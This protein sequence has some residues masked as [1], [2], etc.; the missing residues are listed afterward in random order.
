MKF[1]YIIANPNEEYITLP[2]LKMFA[3]ANGI[4]AP[5]EYDSS[6]A[7]KAAYIK[8]IS[9]FAD[10]NETNQETVL[11]WIDAVVKEGIK[12]IQIMNVPLKPEMEL[13]FSAESTARNY[14]KSFISGTNPH[15]TGNEYSNAFELI[16]YDLD[17]NEHGKSISFLFCRMLRF[18]DIKKGRSEIVEYPVFAEY[19]Y[20]RGWLI[21]RYKSRSGLYDI[22]P[23]GTPIDECLRHS[24]SLGAEIQK[25]YKKISNILSFDTFDTMVASL[26]M[27]NKFYAILDHYTHTPAEIVEIIDEN[28][29]EIENIT[30]SLM[31][32]CRLPGAFQEKVS[33]DIKNLVEKYLSITWEDKKIFIQD[34]EAYPI[35]LSTT[36]EE[37]SRVDQ[38]SATSLDPLQSK[39]VF[40]DNKRMLHNQRLCE[41][42]TLVW[43]RTNRTYYS[44]ATF[45]VR[46]SEKN[47]KCILS[48]KRYAAEEDIQHVLF[49]I[50]DA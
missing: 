10:S 48:F 39:E 22:M 30:S 47:G 14:L 11:N 49:A 32:I 29:S 23:E 50:I 26:T 5:K 45:P 18:Y 6:N 28:Q 31:E 16:R 17:S 19:Y 46:F 42:L 4:P 9:D 2:S 33:T 38:S 7:N 1:P 40:F 35:R 20:E 3:K 12:E 37:E 27:R 36:D 13:L 44:E 25:I 8:A 34:R 24:I 15:L 21:I 41:G 43:K